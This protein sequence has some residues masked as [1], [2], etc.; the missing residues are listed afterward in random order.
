MPARRAPGNQL[1]V[2]MLSCEAS[3]PPDLHDT[4][5]CRS[6]GRGL[7]GAPASRPL[8]WIPPEPPASLWTNP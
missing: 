2:G 7:R 6:G 5:L 1:L 3:L 8:A 4:Q